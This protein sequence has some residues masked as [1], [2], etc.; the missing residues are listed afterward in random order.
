MSAGDRE[1]EG[2][3]G[4]SGS[5]HDGEIL[6]ES[7]Q[8]AVSGQSES[9]DGD[10][11]L[12]DVIEEKVESKIEEKH[13][14]AQ[15][16]KAVPRVKRKR[17]NEE[18]D[19][20]ER[21]PSDPKYDKLKKLYENVVPHLGRFLIPANLLRKMRQRNDEIAQK[22]RLVNNEEATKLI[23][24]DHMSSASEQE[25][26]LW[27]AFSSMT[28]FEKM[29]H[30][31]QEVQKIIETV[32]KCTAERVTAEDYLSGRD[33]YTSASLF[34]GYPSRP[35]ES[36]YKACYVCTAGLCE[37]N[38]ASGPD[39]PDPLSL[40]VSLVPEARAGG[41]FL[42]DAMAPQGTEPV[43]TGEEFVLEVRLGGE[44]YVF[45]ADAGQREHD[46]QEWIVDLKFIPVIIDML[47]KHFTSKA[48]RQL[49]SEATP[50]AIWTTRNLEVRCFQ[51]LN[52]AFEHL[53]FD[54]EL[55]R[56]RKDMWFSKVQEIECGNLV[57]ISI[58]V[59]TL[60]RQPFEDEDGN[61]VAITE[62]GVSGPVERIVVGKV[63]AV[64]GN[65]DKGGR[66]P[67]CYLVNSV[68]VVPQTQGPPIVIIRESKGQDL[69]DRVAELLAIV[70]DDEY[71]SS[72]WTKKG[73]EELLEEHAATQMATTITRTL[74]STFVEFGAEV[75]L[76]SEIDA[77][78]LLPIDEE[79]RKQAV[80]QRQ[81]DYALLPT[82]TTYHLWT[83]TS[84]LEPSGS[85]Q[86]YRQELVTEY[87]SD[88]WKWVSTGMCKP[89]GSAAGLCKELSP[90]D[91]QIVQA[92]FSAIISISGHRVCTECF[93]FKPDEH[94]DANT[95]ALIQEHLD[96]FKALNLCRTN[97]VFFQGRYY[98]PMTPED[99]IV[100][101]LDT[102]VEEDDLNFNPSGEDNPSLSSQSQE[103]D[104]DEEAFTGQPAS[105]DGQRSGDGSSGSGNVSDMSD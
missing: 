22:I 27:Q 25:L 77:D 91:T 29:T 65:L 32:Q 57:G 37:C 90:E 19:G 36:K 92:A 35:M 82:S 40:S 67:P 53:F 68:V 46:S 1:I 24:W 9:D 105:E 11:I 71:Y 94:D 44:L 74:E 12:G 62:D 2:E 39:R 84:E 43:Q 21:E 49:P 87:P 70:N 73:A 66:M 55:R 47:Q 61:T 33:L 14:T 15:P 96:R 99:L 6:S 83:A 17:R 13:E 31:A 50:S 7:E 16:K 48:I 54:L 18:D 23:F 63:V 5:E 38:S 28:E 76:A 60:D 4:E 98:Q 100:E 72:G 8:D 81:V 102:D 64:L 30:I 80:T 42:R 26:A 45:E 88:G 85:V 75:W 93:T 103:W 58:D 3:V 41:S 10:A 86:Y 78:N 59:C 34:M 95:K 97:F 79:L 69:E 89:P 51:S 56:M 52:L 20:D 104:S 101:D